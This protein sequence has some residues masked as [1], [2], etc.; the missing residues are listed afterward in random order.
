MARAERPN[1]WLEVSPDRGRPWSL[2]GLPPLGRRSSHGLPR[3]RH[4]LDEV[5]DDR[6]SE[7]ERQHE[8]WVGWC[9]CQCGWETPVSYSGGVSNAAVGQCLQWGATVRSPLSE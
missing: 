6:W 3:S 9:A 7:W 4:I 2:Y 1:N 5:K 8:D